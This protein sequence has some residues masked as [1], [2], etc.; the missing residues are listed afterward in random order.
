MF[1]NVNRAAV[2]FFAVWL[3]HYV[4][5]PYL[6]N[7]RSRVPNSFCVAKL[8]DNPQLR[9]QSETHD[10]DTLNMVAASNSVDNSAASK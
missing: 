8:A 9:R 7:H 10:S 2:P 5:S 1:R 4:S 3:N 6:K